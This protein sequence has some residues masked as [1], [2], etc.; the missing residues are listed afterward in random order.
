MF[1]LSEGGQG[2][3]RDGVSQILFDLHGDLNGI[4][5]VQTMFSECA[6][7]G[8]TYINIQIPCL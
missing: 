3:C 2:L 5:R 1:D 4:Q 7:L 8:H 6:C